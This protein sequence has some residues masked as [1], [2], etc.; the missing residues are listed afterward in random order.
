MPGLAVALGV[1][2][3][4]GLVI[5]D[6]DR[7]MAGLAVALGEVS[8]VCAKDDTV[9]DVV[10]ARIIREVSKVFIDDDCFRTAAER[11]A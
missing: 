4:P 10:A 3:R 9:I 5:P 8:D 7:V 6:G 11:Q 1:S 2:A